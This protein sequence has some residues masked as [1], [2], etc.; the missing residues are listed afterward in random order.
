MRGSP[1]GKYQLGNRLTALVPV[2]IWQECTATRKRTLLPPAPRFARKVLAVDALRKI[3]G[4]ALC[5]L[6]NSI[7]PTLR[8]D[9]DGVHQ[10]RIAIRSARAAFR[11]FGVEYGTATE[12]KFDSRLRSL[13]QVFGQERDWNVFCLDT[14]PGA[15]AAARSAV[16]ASRLRRLRKPAERQRRAAQLATL[17][18]INGP[19]LTPLI[20]QLAAWVDKRSLSSPSSRYDLGHQQLSVLAPL[21]LNRVAHSAHR[22]ARHV[23]RLSTD[24]LHRVRK[25]VRRLGS[26]A[27]S[28]ASAF[29]RRLVKPYKHRCD[30]VLRILG[31]ISDTVV[32]RRIANLLIITHP[33]LRSA[34]AIVIRMSRCREAAERRTLK[35]ALRA[36][37]RTPAF[38]L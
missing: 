2:R 3:L 33:D 30:E 38:W 7:S 4:G 34:A 36:L 27:T 15:I 10:M 26:D 28:L 13:G 17:R 11:L 20:L 25:A 8:A 21:L 24:K 22:R 12:H 9:P 37:R 1:E 19:L 6:V 35:G 23:D 5:H 32:T 31:A 18:A 16:A 14:L 29:P